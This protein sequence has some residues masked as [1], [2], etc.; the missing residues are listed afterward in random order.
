MREYILM[1]Q[2]LIAEVTV[3]QRVSLSWIRFVYISETHKRIP[4]L[5]F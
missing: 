4:T 1:I 3:R 2:F 5:S